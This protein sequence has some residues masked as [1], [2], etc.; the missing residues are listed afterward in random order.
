MDC[1]FLVVNIGYLV[2]D[3]ADPDRQNNGLPA[4]PSALCN[5]DLLC[6]CNVDEDTSGAF[7]QRLSLSL[8]AERQEKH[9]DLFGGR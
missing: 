8:E 7:I 4:R 1:K 3:F 9:R 6:P 2:A 5:P